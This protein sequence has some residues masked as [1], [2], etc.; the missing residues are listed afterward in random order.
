MHWIGDFRDRATDQKPRTALP[1]TAGLGVVAVGIGSVVLA[2]YTDQVAPLVAGDGNGGGH[3]HGM[4]CLASQAAYGGPLLG[5]VRI[6]DV[7]HFIPGRK[8]LVA[9][10]LSEVFDALLRCVPSP[11]HRATNGFRSFVI[12][13]SGI[14]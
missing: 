8:L 10:L 7:W 13:I 3:G 6:R 9:G 12:P 5:G 14:R 2:G 4:D 1:V 11:S